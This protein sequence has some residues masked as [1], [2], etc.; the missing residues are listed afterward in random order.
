MMGALAGLAGCVEAPEQTGAEIYAAYCAAC[1]GPGGR[2]EGIIAAELPVGPPDLTRLTAEN[3]GFF[4]TARVI[5]K[6]Y[7]YPGDYPLQVMPEFGPL[8][9]GP[10]VRWSDESGAE[11]TTTRAMQQLHDYLVSIQTH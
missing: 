1:H 6:I 2:G 11:I 7:G 4:P 9:T 8:L 5:E 10:A 3:G